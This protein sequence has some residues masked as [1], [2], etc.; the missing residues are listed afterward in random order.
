MKN[1]TREGP[2]LLEDVIKERNIN[3]SIVDLEQG[4]SFPSVE[5]YG[6][7]VVLGGSESAN[8]ENEKMKNQLARIREALAARIPYLG[9]CL[10]LQTLIK[11]AGGNVIKSPVKEIGLYGPDGNNFMVQLTEAGKQDALF[12]DLGDSFDVIHLHGETVE[13]SDEM[14]LLASG[15]FCR[16][17]IVKVGP[18]AYGIQCHFELT[19]E[20][21]E[22]WLNEDPDLVKLD[23]KQLLDGFETIRDKYTRVG[24]RLFTNF[25]TIAGY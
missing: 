25:L 2:G 9:V 10:G 3:Y 17:Q 4:Q 8:D 18:N 12:E 24:L 23:K 16:N 14:T 13:L 1:N 21:F 22:T 6:A 7:V 5:K 20:K 15:S 19:A 11:A